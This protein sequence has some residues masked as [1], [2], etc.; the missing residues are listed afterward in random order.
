MIVWADRWRVA[1]TCVGAS[2]PYKVEV[3]SGQALT[4]NS[5]QHILVC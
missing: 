2:Q 3:P 1:A 4:G 5:T